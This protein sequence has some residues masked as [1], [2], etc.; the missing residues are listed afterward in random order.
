M[1]SKTPIRGLFDRHSRCLNYKLFQGSMMRGTNILDTLRREP[2]QSVIRAQS[3]YEKDVRLG[4]QDPYP[5]ALGEF[6]QAIRAEPNFSEAQLELGVTYHKMGR[7][8]GNSLRA[9]MV[10]R[11][12]N[13]G[14]FLAPLFNSNGSGTSTIKYDS[15]WVRKALIL[16]GPQVTAISEY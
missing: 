2:N 13:S 12:G 15:E 5:E 4:E 9:A 14:N 10:A 11:F 16:T 7:T 3:H 6:K 8:N 1:D